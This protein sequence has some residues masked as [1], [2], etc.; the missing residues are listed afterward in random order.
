MDT[1]VSAVRSLFEM[2]TG[3]KPR[4]R[5]HGGS[6]AENLALQ[7]IQV[8]PSLSRFPSLANMIT[9]EVADGDRLPLRSASALGSGAKRWSTRPWKR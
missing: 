1:V 8:D 3:I 9:G 5:V 7:N 2:V 4:F 6:S